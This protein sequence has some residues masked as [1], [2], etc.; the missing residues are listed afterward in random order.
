MSSVG[1]Q[2]MLWRIFDEC[3][4]GRRL[5][6][7]P[8]LLGPSS[9]PHSQVGVEITD[10]LY[11][12]ISLRIMTRMGSVALDRLKD[13]NEFVRGIHSSGTMN[14][15]LRYICHFPD[16]KLTMSVNSNY[17]GNALLSKKAIR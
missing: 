6:V 2:D 13:N 14:P 9:S 16:T 17:G 10:S 4:R 3:M 12:V 5:Y 15:K 7:V 8:Y 1:A 11:V